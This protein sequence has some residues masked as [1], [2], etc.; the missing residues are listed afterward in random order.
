MEIIRESLEGLGYSTLEVSIY[1]ILLDNGTMSPYQIAKK[2]DIS[3]SSIYNALEHMV[4]KG[5]VEVIPEDT[6]MYIAKE[7][8]VFLNKVESDYKKNISNAKDGLKGYL[9]TRYEEKSALIKGYENIIEKMKYIIDHAEA[10]VFINTDVELDVFEDSFRRAIERKV[11]IVVFSF[12]TSYSSVA[13]VEIYSHERERRL[14]NINSRI[15]IVADENLVMIADAGNARGNW[16][17]TVSNNKLMKAVVREHIHNDIY[18]LKLRNIYGKEI[19]KKIL[20][21]TNQETKDCQETK[22]CQEVKTK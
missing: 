5:M 7:P 9:E 12:F 2:V 4:D 13:E 21:N 15:M 16:T 22:V 3:R 6:V 8:E 19:Y 1:L 10:E 11:R 17:G 14:E 20:L 18:M